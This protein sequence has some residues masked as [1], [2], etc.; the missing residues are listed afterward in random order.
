MG[1]NQKTQFHEIY[2]EH[3]SVIRSKDF[4]SQYEYNTLT[5]EGVEGGGE[6]VR[7][8]ATFQF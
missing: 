7:S 6:G 4:S 3:Q 5:R 1:N 8:G 2:G